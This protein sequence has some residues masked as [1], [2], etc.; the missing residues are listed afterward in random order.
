V[1]SVIDTLKA[2]LTQQLD[3]LLERVRIANKPGDLDG[4]LAH[5][6]LEGEPV[7]NLEWH[8]SCAQGDWLTENNSQIKQ[9][10]FPTLATIGYSISMEQEAKTRKTLADSFV[11]GFQRLQQR[12]LFPADGFSFPLSPK[13]FLGI[14]VGV[15]HLP[16][17]SFKELA[18]EWLKDVFAKTLKRTRRS[19]MSFWYSYISY[20]L[21]ETPEISYDISKVTDLTES[22]FL[23]WA[24]RRQ[25]IEL[26]KPESQLPQVQE[27]ILG[28]MLKNPMEVMGAPE[29]AL[30]LSAAS[31][32]ISRSIHEI[33]LSGSHVA[34]MLNRFEDAMKRWPERWTIENENDVQSIVWVML[35]SCFED[36]VD[37]DTLPKFGHSSYKADFGIPSL[38]LL[39]EVKVVRRAEDFKTVEK[40]IMEDS[41]GYLQETKRYSKLVVFIYDKSSSV[42]EHGTTRQNLR[43]IPAI[44][45]VVIVSR[46]SQLKLP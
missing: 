12:E 35:R 41:I 26:G 1:V 40:E 15:K 11:A 38:G 2:L 8:V 44:E 10:N 46:P 29:A 32:C 17:D 45:D 30:V 24:V 6:I 31:T 7:K 37:E 42:Q 23:M 9:G 43:K 25:V 3:I 14:V 21:N 22:S 5:H 28:L 19:R 27:R 13:A 20:I 16:E 18:I 39:I 4:L 34:A 33:V 36:L